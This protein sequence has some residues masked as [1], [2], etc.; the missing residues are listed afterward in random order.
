MFYYLINKTFIGATLM[1]VAFGVFLFF[2]D[3]F[4]ESLI[5]AMLGYNFYYKD[6][7]FLKL[8]YLVLL[9]VTIGIFSALNRTEH[10]KELQKQKLAT[11]Y[12]LSIIITGIIG[13]VLHIYFVK[14]AMEQEGSLTDLEQNI[15][16]YYSTDL[17]LVLGFVIGGLS[18]R[19]GMH[20]S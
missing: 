15:F 6:P 7:A 9:A 2:I 16:R 19:K 14:N 8:I 13:L 5:S 20:N 4:S 12:I 3:G 11:R 17:F 18:L 1:I 10:L